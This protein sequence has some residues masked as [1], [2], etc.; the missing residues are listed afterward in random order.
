MPGTH[1]GSVVH[2]TAIDDEI[3]TC[4]IAPAPKW[5]V[6]SDVNPNPVSV[7]VVPTGP[8]VG[9]TARSVI[10]ASGTGAGVCV[11]TEVVEVGP[12]HAANAQL[13][14]TRPTYD[15][16]GQSLASMVQAT[17]CVEVGT[18]PDQGAAWKPNKAESAKNG[19]RKN[20]AI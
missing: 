7:T 14:G 20:V 16:S 12:G 15:P 3:G 1:E 10:S 19:A 2:A 6:L 8:E 4:T 5:M 18:I 13:G 9:A 11:G 17:G